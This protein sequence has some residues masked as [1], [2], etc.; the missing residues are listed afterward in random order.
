MDKFL[1]FWRSSGQQRM[2]YLIGKYEEHNDIPLGIRATIVAIY[3]PPQTCTKNSIEMHEDPNGWLVDA[4]LAALGLRR[5]GWILT[6][7][8][9][10]D[11]TKGTVK[12]SRGTLDSYFLSAEE[13]ITAAEFQNRYPNPCRWSSDGIYG[14]K[15]VT[16]IVTGD[17]DNRIHFEGYQVSDQCMGLVRDGCLI[18]TYDAPELG[19]VKESS[20]EQY[21]PDVF[22][23]NKDKYGN[24]ITRLARPL[25]VEYLL[26]DMSVGFPIEQ[27][28]TFSALKSQKN[29]FPAAN[30]DQIGEFQ[31]LATLAT[32]LHQF[33]ELSFLQA[34]SDFDVL[35]Y[36][37]NCDVLPL[38]EHMAPLLEAVRTQD[39]EAAQRWSQDDQWS[40]MQHLLHA[41][42]PSSD[43]PGAAAATSNS[44]AGANASSLTP[45]GSTWQCAHCT[46]I[47]TN[48]T[49]CEMC[50]LP[51]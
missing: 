48:P 39:A 40:T 36:L 3:E 44:F 25:P 2:G 35:L 49:A 30:R 15:F 38:R 24:E 45:V 14:S 47:N 26:T 8:L 13:C 33:D 28:Y 9:A 31:T 6:D 10:E 19:Y 22:Y 5:V 17:K 41:S 21:V 27:L 20:N 16:V 50:S 29:P 7:L 51:K 37:S 12:H 11:L 1:N 46:F 42:V 43:Q 34:L 18:P 32:Y 4:L 23:K